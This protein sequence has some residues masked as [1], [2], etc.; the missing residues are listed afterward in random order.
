MSSRAVHE[1]G[2]DHEVA[3]QRQNPATVF[4]RTVPVVRAVEEVEAGIGSPAVHTAVSGP[5]PV[6]WSERLRLR[7]IIERQRVVQRRRRNRSRRSGS[8]V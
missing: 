6:E 1:I 7:A 8:A 3:M 4:D 2:D 5:R